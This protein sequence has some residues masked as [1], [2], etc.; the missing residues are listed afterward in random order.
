M[1]LQKQVPLYYLAILRI[2]VGYHFLSVGSGKLN[3]Q[4]FTG[5]Q[6]VRQLAG[7]D[8]DPI[9][10]HR[11]F[12]TSIV[13]PNASLFAYLVAFGE[14]LIGLS[15]LAGLLVRVSSLFG[16]FHNLNIYLAIGWAAGGAQLSVN[17]IYILMHLIFVIVGAG[18]SLGLDGLLKKR[19]PKSGIF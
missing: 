12:I 17:R 8:A 9:G 3:A 13:I 5:E 18:R 6:L 7:V 1:A 16:A 14:V 4:F 2:M 10:L 15:L 11:A 19:F